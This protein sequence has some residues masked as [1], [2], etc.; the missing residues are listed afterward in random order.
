MMS[1]ERDELLKIEHYYKQ[2]KPNQKEYQVQFFNKYV[3]INN[4]PK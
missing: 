3:S 2:I 1:D 4:M